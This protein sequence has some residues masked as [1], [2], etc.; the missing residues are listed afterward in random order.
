[1]D[2]LQNAVLTPEPRA[3]PIMLYAALP[4]VTSLQEPARTALLTTC[5]TLLLHLWQLHSSDSD[6]GVC[7]AN[8]LTYMSMILAK[9]EGLVDWNSVAGKETLEVLMLKFTGIFVGFGRSAHPDVRASVAGLLSNLKQ[10]K[11]LPAPLNDALQRL[12]TDNRA[13]VRYRAVHSG[14]KT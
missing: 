13:R 1:M 3:I 6:A 8:A 12:V 4:A 11:S 14:L 10:W 5:Q 2:W 9:E 7:L